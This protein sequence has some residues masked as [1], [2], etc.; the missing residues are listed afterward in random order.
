MNLRGVAA[1]RPFQH[2]DSA[3]KETI[4]RASDRALGNVSENASVPSSVT[5]NSMNANEL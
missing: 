3:R 4:V 5:D 2:F 1:L